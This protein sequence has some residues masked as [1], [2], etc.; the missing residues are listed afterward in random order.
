[1]KGPVTRKTILLSDED[2]DGAAVAIASTNENDKNGTILL[3][4][5]NDDDDGKWLTKA[6]A[7][8][9][10][11]AEKKVIFKEYLVFL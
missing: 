8:V 7:G 10:G 1:M 2:E 3:G 4:M 6:T 9:G 11:K 5:D